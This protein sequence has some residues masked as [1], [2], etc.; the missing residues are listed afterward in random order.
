VNVT[1]SFID[2]IKTQ[3]V[4][5]ELFGHYQPK[6]VASSDDVTQLWVS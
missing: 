5:F 3:P 6:R 1:Q 2:Y 4:V